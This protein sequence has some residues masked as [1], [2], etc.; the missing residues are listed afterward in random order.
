MFPSGSSEPQTQFRPDTAEIR[1]GI[2]LHDVAP[3][4]K[5]TATWIAEKA[6]GVPLNYKIDSSTVAVPDSK[7]KGTTFRLSKPNNGWPVGDYRVDVTYNGRQ[8][9]SQHFKV[10]EGK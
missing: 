2:S 1:V 4:D 6:N 3:G 10:V 8:E 5:V 9:L 7:V